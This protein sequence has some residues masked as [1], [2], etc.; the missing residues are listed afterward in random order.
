MSD[1]IVRDYF[2]PNF[3]AYLDILGYKSIFEGTT[4]YSKFGTNAATGEEVLFAQDKALT[5]YLFSNDIEH[6]IATS[7]NLLNMFNVDIKQKVFSDNFLFCTTNDWTE[8]LV[9]VTILQALFVE[10]G[11]FIRGSLCHGDLHYSED[12]ISGSG[13]IKAVELES[14]AKSPRIIIDNSFYE[15]ASKIVS[16]ENG[17]SDTMDSLFAWSEKVGYCIKDSDGKAIVDYLGN[18]RVNVSGD[19]TDGYLNL[20]SVLSRH[21]FWISHYANATQIMGVFDKYKW[22]MDYHNNFCT[23]YGYTDFLIDKISITYYGNT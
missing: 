10:Q 23:Q 18:L 19:A 22:C 20:E 8:L 11:I 7:K 1:K 15:A 5:P 17:T 6:Y 2:K 12:F 9:F 3:I 16:S 21:K 4:I 14:N 13:L